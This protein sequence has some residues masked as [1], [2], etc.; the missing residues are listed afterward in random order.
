MYGVVYPETPV[1]KLVVSKIGLD[2]ELMI[3]FRG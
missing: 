2:V 1:R 3:I